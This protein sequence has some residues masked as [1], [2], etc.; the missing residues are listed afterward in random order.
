MNDELQKQIERKLKESTLPSILD[1]LG[2]VV[3]ERHYFKSEL[4]RIG[5][6]RAL[7]NLLFRKM[8]QEMEALRMERDELKVENELIKRYMRKEPNDIYEQLEAYAEQVVTLTISVA[9]L[10]V[11]NRCAREE[12]ENVHTTATELKHLTLQAQ[13]LANLS[14]LRCEENERK[15]VEQHNEMYLASARHK[16]QLKKLES[17]VHDQDA[18]ISLLESQISSLQNKNKEIS[19]REQELRQELANLTKKRRHC[20]LF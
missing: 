16:E 12:L 14:H 11:E 4:I 19:Q 10:N 9:I 20:K 13:H 8:N 2:T 17:T 18:L 3:Y 7:A 15:L 1:R 5:Q 6:E